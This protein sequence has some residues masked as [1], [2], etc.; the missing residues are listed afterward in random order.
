MQEERHPVLT[1]EDLRARRDSILAVA[2]K[3]GASDVRIFGSVAR[4][5]ATPQSDVDILVAFPPHYK[6]LDQAALLMDLKDLL[7]VNVDVSV[8]AN[9]KDTVREHVLKDA[10]PL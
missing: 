1:L 2:D 9:L 8:E 3:Y 4:G 7:G 6:L 10:V 5:E